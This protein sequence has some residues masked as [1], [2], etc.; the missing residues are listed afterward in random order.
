MFKIFALV[1]L[2]VL[3][4]TCSKVDS[5]SKATFIKVCRYNCDSVLMC[6]DYFFTEI[7][8]AK[9]DSL[10]IKGKNKAK[11]YTGSQPNPTHLQFLKKDTLVFILN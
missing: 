10:G 5:E 4:Y 2:A 7:D 9:L 6:K 8:S 11:A 3:I 1:A